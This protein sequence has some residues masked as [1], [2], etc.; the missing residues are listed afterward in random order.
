VGAKWPLHHMAVAYA[1]PMTKFRIS[2]LHNA[3]HWMWSVSPETFAHICK[4]GADTAFQALHLA[5]VWINENHARMS[6]VIR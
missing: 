1:D 4:Q 3:S 5:Q 2:L 6:Q